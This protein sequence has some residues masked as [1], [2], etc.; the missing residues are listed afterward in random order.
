[1]QF[2]PMPFLSQGFDVLDRGT[3]NR[4]ARWWRQVCGTLATQCVVH[5]SAASPGVGVFINAHPRSTELE[6]AL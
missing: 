4:Q 6:S 3:I 5:G 2:R 1:M